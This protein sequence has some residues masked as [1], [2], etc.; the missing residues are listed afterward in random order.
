MSLQNTVLVKCLECLKMSVVMQLFTL[1]NAFMSDSLTYTL[2][3]LKFAISIILNIMV[4]SDKKIVPL[5]FTEFTKLWFLVE[6]IQHINLSM[7]H[8][9]LFLALYSANLCLLINILIWTDNY[10]AGLKYR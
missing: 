10:T 2:P 5:V 4:E 1:Q 8:S 6:L 9:S 7:K 3:T